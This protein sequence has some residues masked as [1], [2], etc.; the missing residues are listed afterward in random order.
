LNPR[1]DNSYNITIN[2]IELIFQQLINNQKIN[3]IGDILPNFVLLKSTV[4]RM[5]Y[6]IEK[7]TMGEVKVPANKYW[8]LQCH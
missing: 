7:D 2:L 1:K 4:K 5:E 3:E 8:G 6:R